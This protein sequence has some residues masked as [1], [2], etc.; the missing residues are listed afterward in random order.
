MKRRRIFL[1]VTAILIVVVFLAGFIASAIPTKAATLQEQ[2]AEAQNQR[3]AAE[4]QLTNV[5][6]QK[7][8]AEADMVKIQSEIDE[9]TGKITAVESEITATNVK[10]EEKEKELEVA[11]TACENQ[12]TSFK[13]R[14]RIMYE[15]GPSTYIEILFGS[16]SFSEFLSNIQIIKSLLEYDNK[17]LEER[18]AVRE[19]IAVQ[20]AEVESIKAEQETRRNTLTEMKSTLA[21]K[22]QTQ[23]EMVAQLAGQEETIKAAIENQKAEEERIQKL[24][25]D[26]VEKERQAAAA[27]AE[28]ER[29]AAESAAATTTTTTTTTG[30]TGTMTWPCPSTKR[31]TSEFGKRSQPVAGA[32]TY[33]KGLDIAG[34]MGVDIVA[35]DAGTVLFS[36]NSSSYG[37]YIVI[38]HGNGITTLYAHC[39]QL[40]VKAGAS[41]SKGQVIAKVGS[42][43]IS[44]GPHLHFE[45]SV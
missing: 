8:T 38:S 27:A 20:K 44:S 35:A 4:Q 40:L 7:K 11:E 2:L 30:G 5:Q 9:L 1:S 43:G 24:I 41:V 37:K 33:H 18:K 26:A 34:Y 14:A 31:V 29:K 12:F 42:T 23:S 21:T 3:K 39:S 19:E 36:G 22:K 45:V 15:S 13:T 16:G 25:A 17:V 28:A 6:Q 32:S 10:L